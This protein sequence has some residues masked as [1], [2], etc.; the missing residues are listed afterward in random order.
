MI[1]EQRV[2]IEAPRDAVWAVLSDFPRAARLM[3][4]VGEVR[5]VEDGG[6]EGLMRVRV[7]PIGLNISGT[8]YVEQ[9]DENGRWSMKAGAQDKRVGGGVQAKID[10][11]LT[12]LSG[13][14]SELNVKAD[15]QLMGRLGQMGQPLIRRKAESTMRQFA[16]N[17]KAAATAD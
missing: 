9:D 12:E 11:T 16:D 1:F 10:V 14:T 17:L 3:P 2:I 5:Q 4:D 13:E 8:V 7:G 6:Y 15:V